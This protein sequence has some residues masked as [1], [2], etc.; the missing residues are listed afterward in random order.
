VIHAFGRAQLRDF[1]VLAVKGGQAQCFQM[2]FE[3]KLGRIHQA[4]SVSKLE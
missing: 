4:T 1:V 3:Q 2:V